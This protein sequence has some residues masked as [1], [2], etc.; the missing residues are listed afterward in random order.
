M[1]ADVKR[2]KLLA[3]Y[4]FLIV[5][6]IQIL[7]VSLLYLD[8]TTLFVVGIDFSRS[9]PLV[10]VSLFFGII[11]MQII[12]V[13]GIAAQTL[14]KDDLVELSPN[15]DENTEWKCRYSRDSIVEWV[16]DLAK[17]SGVVVKKIYLMNSPL[18]NA[19]TFSLPFLGSVV[20]VHSNTLE[21]LNENEVKAIITHELGHIKNKDSIV[22]IFT[23]M[24]SFFVD[25]IY[26]YVYSDRSWSRHCIACNWRPL[27]RRSTFGSVGCL[28]STL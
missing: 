18:P 19:F 9:N 4:A 2:E 15:Y 26:I 25:L 20:V 11:V 16:Q 3:I 27:Y 6:F 28:L 23:R 12:M 14:R 10:S 5:D 21:V 17:M 22:Q 8:D 1:V 13:Y 24:P 7:F